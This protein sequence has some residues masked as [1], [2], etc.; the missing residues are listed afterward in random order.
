MWKKILS[1][2]KKKLTDAGRCR[3]A[4]PQIIANLGF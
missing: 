1:S 4:K 3:V 2:G